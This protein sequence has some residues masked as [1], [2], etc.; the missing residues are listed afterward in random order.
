M[1]YR[2]KKVGKFWRIYKIKDKRFIKT[3][4]KTKQSATNTVI[5]WLRYRHEL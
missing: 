2:I 1:P 5:N 3:K 4:Y